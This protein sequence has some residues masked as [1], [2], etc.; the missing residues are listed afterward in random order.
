MKKLLSVLLVILM[1][2]TALPLSVSAEG[3][4]TAISTAEELLAFLESADNFENA[5]VTLE[6]DII[7][8][9]GAF[10]LNDEN[11]PM[12]NSTL[13]LPTV[14]PSMQSFKGTFDGNGYTISGLYTA[15]GLFESCEN[16][17]VK[18]VNLKNCLVYNENSADSVG[19]LSSVGTNSTFENCKVDA[20][21]VSNATNVGGALGKTTS[22]ALKGIRNFGEVYSTNKR[23]VGGLVG[24]TDGGTVY[25]CCNTGKITGFAVGGLIG[26]L[27]KTKL[28]SCFNTGEVTALEEAAGGLAYTIIPF[29]NGIIV[30]DDGKIHNKP[31]F[32]ITYCYN[33][34]KINAEAPGEICVFYDGDI[35][36]MQVVKFVADSI[37]AVDSYDMIESYYERYMIEFEASLDDWNTADYMPLQRG[38]INTTEENIKVPT[39]GFCGDAGNENNGYPVLYNYHDHVWGEYT[40]NGDNT[41]TASCLCERCEVLDTLQLESKNIKISTA[42]ELLEFL[43]SAETYENTTVTLEN[44]IIVNDGVFSLNDENKPMYNSSLILPTA[45]STLALFKGTFDGQGHTISGLYTTSGLFESCENAIVKNVNFE[46]CCVNNDGSSSCCGLI[47]NVAANSTFENIKNTSFVTTVGSKGSYT[48]GAFG[49]LESCTVS[50]VRNYGETYSAN[51]KVGGLVGYT[52]LG[53]I[54]ECLNQGKVS[55]EKSGGLIG[56]L[57]ETKIVGCYNTGEVIGTQCAG[58]LV[59]HLK[60]L[61]NEI[62]VDSSG[63][64]KKSDRSI[65]YCYNAGIVTAPAIGK[66]CGEF[67]LL[68]DIYEFYFCRFAGG[69]YEDEDDIYKDMREADSKGTISQI[70]KNNFDNDQSSDENIYYTGNLRGLEFSLTRVPEESIKTF[71][72]VYSRYYCIDAGNTNNGFVILDNYHDHVWGDYVA[73]DDGTKTASCLCKPCTCENTIPSETSKIINVEYQPSRETRNTFT[74]TVKN[75]PTQVQFIEPDGGTRTY[76]RNHKNVTVK[77]YDENGNEV[78]SL[79]RTLAYEVWSIYSNMSAGVEIK[80]RAKYL[81]G[82]IYSWDNATYKFTVVLQ[83]PDAA[84]R[85]VTPAATSGRF[86][87]VETVVVTGPDAEAIRFKMENGTTATYFASRATT[88]ENGDLQFVGKAWANNLGENIITVQVRV[89]GKWQTAATFTY[90]ADDYPVSA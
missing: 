89:K 56:T 57:K 72:G 55:G 85:S 27:D 34:G 86:G 64:Y 70:L 17:T 88:L 41:K 38:F 46:N 69:T 53:S 58:G 30:S 7:V 1:L 61:V 52:N 25:E 21:V 39:Y 42:A 45:A 22:C 4:S 59:Y 74:V 47:A 80:A 54:T 16:A 67:D 65:Q 24:Y 76:D 83:S 11:K 73:N 82:A 44:D 43:G 8:N 48:G 33:A 3:G 26:Y 29:D 71:L 6:N 35:F 23:Y 19:A 10:S 75:R 40:D 84:V 2:I 77:S 63:N 60:P 78:N 13:T 81:E 68:G 66:F 87:A 32:S 50:G 49:K 18:N 90:T 62:Y 9:D 28:S 5:T 36:E 20:I 51:G 79:D 15:S 37:E 31:D 12:Y 14:A